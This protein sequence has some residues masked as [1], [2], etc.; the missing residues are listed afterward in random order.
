MTAPDRQSE[1][2]PFDAIFPRLVK[3]ESPEAKL[4]GFIAYGLYLEAK[5]EWVSDF[6]AREQRYPG[7][8]ELSTYERSWTPSR[9]EAL[10]NAAAQLVTAYTDS[11]V[12]QAEK[13]ILRSA[14]KGGF[15][16][17]VGRWVVGALLYTVLLFALAIGL[18]KS[19]V[20]T[21]ILDKIIGPHWT[22]FD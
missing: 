8:E 11:V 21:G 13:H 5:R 1:R 16:R 20:H 14:L 18:I 17:A 6:Q 3:E 15:W 22:L 9:L 2:P 19:G 7:D 10:E 4:L 12:T